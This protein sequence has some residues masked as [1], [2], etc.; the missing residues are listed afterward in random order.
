MCMCACVYMATER[1]QWYLS[2]A[3]NKAGLKKS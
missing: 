3:V 2:D 1:F